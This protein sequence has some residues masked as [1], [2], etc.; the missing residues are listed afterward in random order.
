MRDCRV[1]DW[2][3]DPDAKNR[4]QLRA[5]SNIKFVVVHHSGV[6]ADNSAEEIRRYHRDSLGWPG[7][8][9]SFVIRKD[10]E[11]EHSG[12]IATV[13]YH[14]AARNLECLGICLVGDFTSHHPT[15]E[16]LGAAHN[17]VSVLMPLL[18]PS[19]SGRIKVKGH[20]ELALPGHGT[21]CP[22]WTWPEWRNAF[23]PWI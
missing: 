18:D 5:L 22:G 13:R 11:I 7:I 3:L 14:V 17:L 6:D 19:E 4:Y 1:Q 9:Y 23:W 8:G 21:S 12:D 10:G 15:E 20:G 16:Q 2:S